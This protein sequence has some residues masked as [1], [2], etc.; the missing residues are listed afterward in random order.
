MAK[1]KVSKPS[2]KPV[3]KVVRTRKPKTIDPTLTALLAIYELIQSLD[4]RLRTVSEPLR[5]LDR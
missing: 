2:S 3:K 4:K 5:T 1:Q